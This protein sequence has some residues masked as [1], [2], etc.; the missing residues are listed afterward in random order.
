M[1][2]LDFWLDL[3]PRVGANPVDTGN[4]QEGVLSEV[5]QDVY[6]QNTDLRGDQGREN[7]DYAGELHELWL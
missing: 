5:V 4:I 1:L 7:Q 2:Y 3:S 6:P